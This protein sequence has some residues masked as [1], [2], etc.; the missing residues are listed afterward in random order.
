MLAEL[1]AEVRAALG[2]VVLA[3]FDRRLKVAGWRGALAKEGGRRFRSRTSP[4][5]YLVDETFPRLTP[6]SLAGA[7]VH[8]SSITEV[9]YRLDLSAVPHSHHTP[10]YLRSALAS[11][12]TV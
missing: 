10:A 11:G 1:V 6:A 4:L 2:G 9:R 7:G 8:M 12:G 3:D 5:L